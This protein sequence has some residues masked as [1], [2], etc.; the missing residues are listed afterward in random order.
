MFYPYYDSLEFGSTLP[1]APQLPVS[2]GW[3]GSSGLEVWQD[4][5]DFHGHAYKANGIVTRHIKYPQVESNHPTGL[6]GCQVDNTGCSWY[7]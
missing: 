1:V 4:T 3:E 7:L 2:R 5:R 6:V